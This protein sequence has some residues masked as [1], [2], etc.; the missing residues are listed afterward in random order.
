VT[1]ALFDGLWPNAAD[2]VSIR[3][4]EHGATQPPTSATTEPMDFYC[5]AY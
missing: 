3:P 5:T 1:A 4:Q 2:V